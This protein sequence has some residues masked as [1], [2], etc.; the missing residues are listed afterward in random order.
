LNKKRSTVAAMKL[1][2]NKDIVYALEHE[3]PPIIE[4]GRFYV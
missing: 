2:L 4:S 1:D 3:D